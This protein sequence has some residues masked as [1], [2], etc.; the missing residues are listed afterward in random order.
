VIC[1]RIHHVPVSV[2]KK[3]YIDTSLQRAKPLFANSVKIEK[4]HTAFIPRLVYRKRGELLMQ[5]GV[6]IP[7][8]RTLLSS[9][10][11]QIEKKASTVEWIKI[12]SSLS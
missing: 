12:I 1:L 4:K 3:K 6:L 10:Q 9:H 2:Y 5:R 8:D 7:D 11:K